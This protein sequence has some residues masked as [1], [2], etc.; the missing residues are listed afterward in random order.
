MIKKIEFK[1]FGLMLKGNLY[2]PKDFD[3]SKKYNAIVSASPF[4]QVKEQVLS[5]Y[6][7]EMSNRGFIFLAFDYMGMGES[8]ALPGEYKKSRY[9]FRLIE[10]TWD[11][12]SFL[13][14]LPYVDK[15]FGMAVCQGGTILASA[16]VTDRRIEKLALI[17]GM[18]SPDYMQWADPK[19]VSVAINAA[20]SAKQKMYETSEPVYTNFFGFSDETTQEEFVSNFPNLDVMESGFGYYGKGGIA[21]PDTIENF[22][23]DHIGDQAMQSLFSISEHYADKIIQPTLVIHGKKAMTFKSGETFFNKLT[24]KKKAIFPENYTHVDFYYKSEPIKLATDE[25]TKWFNA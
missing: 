14:T 1:S 13:K 9:M 19:M 3:E 17:S 7:N 25:A 5:V 4:P 24:A 16:A 18:M 21:G 15:V 6:G 8:P 22:T 12:V 23:N 2:V 11:A 20:N 10:N